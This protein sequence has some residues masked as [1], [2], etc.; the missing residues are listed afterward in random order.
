[1]NANDFWVLEHFVKMHICED[2]YHLIKIKLDVLF[3]LFLEFQSTVRHQLN[4]RPV[5]YFD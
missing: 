1:M 4:F 3:V 5:V 2:I